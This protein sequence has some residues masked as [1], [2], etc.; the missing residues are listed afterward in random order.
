[1]AALERDPA[2]RAAVVDLLG[3]LAYGELVAV[4]RLAADAAMAPTIADEAEL[5][6]L[7]AMEQRHFVALRDRLIDLGADPYEA[8][9]PFR[10]PLIA[11]HEF[12]APTTWLEGLMK[13]YVGDGFAT[14]FFREIGSLLDPRTR[15]LVL[16]VCE[17][18]RQVEYVVNRLRSAIAADPAVAGR[19]ALWGRR[20]VGETLTQAQRVLA[21]RDALTR[22]LV[23]GIAGLQTDLH[24]V[25]RMISR[26][27]D[28]HSRRM[29]ALGM[30]A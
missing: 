21:E 30:Q 5:T 19:L 13:V 20:L 2:Y 4:E 24:G 16:E 6:A 27:T 22:L 7:A 11:F 26:L 23:G 25:A 8:M 14:D 28:E 12:T 29:S 3:A 1:M 10:G 9:A 15:D 18:L 17:D